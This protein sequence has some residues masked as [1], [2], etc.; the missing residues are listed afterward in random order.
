MKRFDGFLRCFQ[1]SLDCLASFGSSL[2]ASG[3]GVGASSASSDMFFS[4]TSVVGRKVE[5]SWDVQRQNLEVLEAILQLLVIFDTFS[6]MY[7]T[8]FDSFLTER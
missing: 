5:A 3:T 8:T 7:E 2:D 4:E 1:T 6:L